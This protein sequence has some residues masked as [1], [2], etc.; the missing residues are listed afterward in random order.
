MSYY[1]ENDQILTKYEKYVFQKT[2]W[3]LNQCLIHKFFEIG[4]K[5]VEIRI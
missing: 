2:C 1:G 5:G 3:S 4:Y